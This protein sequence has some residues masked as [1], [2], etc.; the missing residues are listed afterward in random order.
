MGLPPKHYGAFFEKFGQ[1]FV[2][3]GVQR[4]IFNKREYLVQI[5]KAAVFPRDYA[6][7]MTIY[8][9]I[10]AYNRVVTVDIGGFT[11]DYLLLREG[12]PDLSVCDSLEKGVIT[13]YNRIIS[14]VS[15]DFDLLLEDTDIDTIILGKNSD[16][17][18]SVIRLVKQ[19]TKQYVDDFLGA[20]R[21]RGIDL[22]TGCI[23]FIGGGA[24]LLREYLENTDKIGKCVLL[25]ISVRMQRDMKFCTRCRKRVAGDCYGSRKEKSVCD[26]DRIQEE[27]P[28]AYPGGRVPQFDGERKGPV[29]CK[30]DSYIQNIR[31]SRG[32]T[33][34]KRICVL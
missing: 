15:S 9:Q 25:R 14:R 5:T 32:S 17:I 13:L 4:F 8:P 22:K 23:V 19:M 2:R 29:Y 31:R 21:E 7:A 3:P 34:D 18:D 24:K 16:Y 11:L 12:R 27:Q 10:A 30:G 26:D 1:Y 20:F 6:A 28:G 33:S